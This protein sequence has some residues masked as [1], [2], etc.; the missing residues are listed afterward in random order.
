M[1]SV[2]ELSRVAI[3]KIL[4]ATDFSSESQ[5]A[6]QYA[7]S[8]AKRYE[9]KLFIAHAVPPDAGTTS[10]EMQLPVHDLMPKQR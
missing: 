3:S 8:L 6:L 4:L 9:S 2:A 5:L 10:V 7:L 1:E